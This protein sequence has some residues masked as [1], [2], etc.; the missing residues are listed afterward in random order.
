M[1]DDETDT[2]DE[3]E[4]FAETSCEHADDAGVRRGSGGSRASALEGSSSSI[5]ASSADEPCSDRRSSPTRAR[6]FRFMPRDGSSRASGAD[7]ERRW[8]RECD[9][10][11]V[12]G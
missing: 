12:R 11:S 9:G 7:S 3:A 4:A 8:K 6:I 5:I 2:R 10:G 1:D